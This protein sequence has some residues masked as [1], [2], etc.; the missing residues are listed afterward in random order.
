MKEDPFIENVL[1]GWEYVR[2]HQQRFFVALLVVVVAAAV[3]AWGVHSRTQSR[4]RASSQFADALSAFRMGDLKT[5]EELFTLTSNSYRG[6]Q[7][8]VYAQYFLGKCALESG[9]NLDAVKAFDT[10]L[11]ESERHPFFRDAALEGKAVAYE[12]EERYV[13]AAETY[14]EL[15]KT[16]TNTLME[17]SALRRAVKDFRLANQP[18]RAIELLGTLIDEAT[19][20][21]KRDLEIELA[22]LKG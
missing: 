14:L 9:R 16:K 20:V 13:E 19:G 11:A 6:S 12:N 22:V 17:T 15:A 7:E 5:A 18:Q 2:E 21:E 8:A 10:Y 4:V 1:R 3:A